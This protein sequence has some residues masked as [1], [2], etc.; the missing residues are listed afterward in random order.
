MD[1]EDIV[2]DIAE[3]MLSCLGYKVTLAAKGEEA[4]ELYR[5]A[6]ENGDGFDVVIMDL[7]IPNGMGGEQAVKE[8]LGIDTNARV[9][10]STGYSSDPIVTEFGDYGFCGCITKPFDLKALQNAM[11]LALS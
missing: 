8:V 3:Q 1:D 6:H 11:D 4:I 9:I 2:A 7:N 10:V 5:Q